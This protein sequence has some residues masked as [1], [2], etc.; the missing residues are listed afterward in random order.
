MSGH[1]PSFHLHRA[2]RRLEAAGFE[3]PLTDAR[4]LMA[5]VLGTNPGH[6]F[7]LD[8]IEPAQLELF[9]ANIER[10]LGWE[11]VQYITGTA[12]FRYEELAVAPGVFIPRPESELL[13]DHALAFLTS[14][15]RGE[16]RVVE[17]CAGSGAISR[18][19]AREIPVTDQWAV[20]ISDDAM[21][22]LERNLREVDVEVVH[23]DM[24]DALRELD[25]TVDL[26]VVNPPYVPLWA[27]HLLPGDVEFDPE[28]AVFA[29][30]DGLD[31]LRVVADVAARLLKPGGRLVTEHDESHQDQVV[32]LFGEPLF[33]RA[34]GH[35]D[36]AGRPRLVSADRSDV[37][38]LES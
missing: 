3:S 16:R 20:E 31:S 7:M 22:W 21:P 10:R 4:I 15:P 38:G 29:G 33:S 35:Q 1:P 14:R 6:L 27:R 34:T 12:P 37:A 8:A 13:V 2:A 19:I 26:V 11:P 36:L 5:D 25:G 17:L 32:A 24:A 18:S 9:E 30:P 23:A 28:A